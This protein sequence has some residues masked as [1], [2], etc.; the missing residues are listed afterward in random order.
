M[1]TKLSQK[2]ER[3]NASMARIREKTNLPNAVIEDVATA[4]EQLGT[5]GGETVKTNIYKVATMT[6]RDAITDMVEGDMCVVHASSM[7]NMQVTDSV[8]AITFPATVVLP[9]AFTGNAWISIR[10]ADYNSDVMIDLSQTRMRCDIMGNDMISISYTSTD[11]ITYTRTDSNAETIEFSSPVS[12]AYPEEWNDVLGYFLQVGGVEF[13]GLFEYKDGVWSSANIG[14]SLNANALMP[15]SKAYTNT[16]VVEGAFFTVKE[17]S[18]YKTLESMLDNVQTLDVT[19]KAFRADSKK[20]RFIEDAIDF[21]SLETLYDLHWNNSGSLMSNELELKGLNLNVADLP[22]SGM[23]PFYGAQVNKFSFHDM[24]I[25]NTKIASWFGRITTYGDSKYYVFEDT[26]RKLYNL[27]LPNC[28]SMYG[29]FA[30]NS[31]HTIEI[32]NII[33]PNMTDVGGLFIYDSSIKKCVVDVKSDNITTMT[34]MCNGCSSLVEADLSAM[35][36]P[37]LTSTSGMFKDCK[38]LEKID[39]RNMTFSSVANYT[40]MFTNVPANCLIIVKDSTAKSW[41]TSKFTNLT[42]VKTVAEYGG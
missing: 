7:A 18:D 30:N 15:G 29:I 26:Y 34:S 32:K 11:G 25:Y 9:S 23:N 19:G 27:Y 39:I 31:C 42:N 22:E 4:V 40:D 10:S 16:G 33:A 38:K 14:I 41:I 37:K 5:S 3:I 2:L 21:E 1:S 35:K 12:C 17:Q 28:T 24:F 20:A 8:T 6:E 36:S 13:G